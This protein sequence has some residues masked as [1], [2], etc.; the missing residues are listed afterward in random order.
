MVF[1]KV[2]T[3]DEFVAEPVFE[4]LG[5]RPLIETAKVADTPP[6]PLDVSALANALRG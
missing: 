2:R 4:H 5:S 1:A 3:V 6:E